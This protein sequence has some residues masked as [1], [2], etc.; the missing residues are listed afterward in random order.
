MR[1][2]NKIV[3]TGGHAGSTALATLQALRQVENHWE[4][5]WVGNK[6]AVEGKKVLTL[7]FRYFPEYGVKCCPLISGKL[8]RKWSGFGILSILKVP[9]GFLHA[10]ALMVFIRPK[11][12]ISFGGFAALPVV[13]TA[14]LF[15][16]PVIVHEQTSAAGLANK[17]SAPFARKIAI[18]RAE[19][20]KYF[21]R[22]KTVLTGNPVASLFFEIKP[23]E[24]I[25]RPPVV[26]A[27][28]GS[29]GSQIFNQAIF[30]ALENLVKEYRFIHL[31]GEIDLPKAQKIR[32]GLEV[33]LRKRYEVCGT[34][35]PSQ[36][37]EYFRKADIILA[38]AGANT[39]AEVMA[40][41][42]PAIFVPI[43]WAQHDEQTKNAQ[44]VKNAGLAVIIKQEDLS[45]RVLLET[46]RK[47]RVGW[48]RFR[49]KK[50]EFRMIDRE[51]ARVLSGLA[52]D[53]A[54]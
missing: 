46:V 1:K 24:E 44:I 40:S 6:W 26:L 7:E 28:G 11:V 31:C 45:A 20:E 39:A 51:A 41:Q 10:A 5:F 36:M 23:K 47:V 3:L 14:W 8:H 2:T 17:L 18:S 35:P 15:R 12:V 53:L 37:P 49:L 52:L 54:K 48:K 34:A 19:S 16:I 43:P 33:S 13:S 27:T 42:R 29:R 32:N 38:R 4:I 30:D 21:P 22:G 50:K 9:F 25:G